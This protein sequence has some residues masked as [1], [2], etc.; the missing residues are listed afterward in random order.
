MH[1]RINFLLNLLAPWT[2]FGEASGTFLKN[3]LNVLNK[4]LWITKETSWHGYHSI[5]RNMT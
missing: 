5:S 2:W 3:F 4:I 1:S